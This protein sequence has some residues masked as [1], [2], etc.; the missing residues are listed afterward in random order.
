MAAVQM[1]PRT[2]RAL[3]VGGVTLLLAACGSS[4]KGPPESTSTRSV[5]CLEVDNA[6]RQLLSEAG[7]PSPAPT[8]GSAEY[9]AARALLH[10]IADHPSCFDAGTVARAQAALDSSS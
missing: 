1:G 6:G 3:T 2:S 4:P 9:V 10:L 5:E 7:S 8:R